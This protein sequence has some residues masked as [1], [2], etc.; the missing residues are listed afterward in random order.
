MSGVVDWLAEERGSGAAADTG[1]AVHMG[2]RA[3]H[4]P[5]KKDVAIALE[6]MRQALPKYPLADLGSAEQQFRLYARDRRNAEADVVLCE[7]EGVLILPTPPGSEEPVFVQG[8]LDQVRR[9]RGAL[10]LYDIK[11]GGSYE[12]SDMPPYH[13]A[14]L[15]AYQLLATQILSEPVRRCVVI[16]TKDYMKSRPGPVFW[17][18]PWTLED[19]RSLMDEVRLEVG[20]IRSGLIR[21]TPS[22]EQCKYCP[23]TSIGNCFK[24]RV[25]LCPASQG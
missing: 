12:G 17:E 22:C 6:V 2:A 8:T 3:F 4:G 24:R 15:C 11:T 9:E 13:A 19:A 23:L 21:I 5:A 7:E 18:C 14:Q 25:Q 16:R 1:S 20:R 10:V